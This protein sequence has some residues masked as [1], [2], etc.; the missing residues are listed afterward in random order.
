MKQFQL[1][2]GFQLLTERHIEFVWP[3]FQLKLWQH[4]TWIEYIDYFLL[5]GEIFKFYIGLHLV[6]IT[7]SNVSRMK[8]R[9]CLVE[10]DVDGR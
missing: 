10:I 3:K 5:I 2:L 1:Y 6:T 8:V 9:E 4:K 7:I